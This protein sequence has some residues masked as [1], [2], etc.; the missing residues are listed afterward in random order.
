MI[1]G[2]PG[3]G[4]STQSDMLAKEFGLV[5]ISPV[6]L[7][8]EQEKKVTEQTKLHTCAGELE[9]KEKKVAEQT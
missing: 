2:P 7:L 1:L 3:S 8:K 5:L 6:E 4:K 9:E